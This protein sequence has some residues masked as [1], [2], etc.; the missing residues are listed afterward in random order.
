MPEEELE[1][2]KAMG[3][4]VETVGTILDPDWGKPVDPVLPPILADQ[5]P[6][7]APGIYF[8]MPE[9][10]YHAI[11]AVSASGLKKLATSNM[12]YW[13]CSPLNPDKEE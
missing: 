12:D 4:D 10:V 11:H 8:G 2:L 5:P 3:L 9:D 13:A 1:R 7:P 6:F